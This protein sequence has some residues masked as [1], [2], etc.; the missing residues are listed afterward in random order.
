VIVPDDLDH[1]IVDRPEVAQLKVKAGN[2]A[3]TT[4]VV[5]ADDFKTEITQM[6]DQVETNQEEKTTVTG[7]TTNED[8][9]ILPLP[10][11]TD[12]IPL[13]KNHQ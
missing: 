9:L 11:P 12:S 7:E 8:G 10:S 13:M 4:V 6:V 1:T 5:K 3:K 2:E